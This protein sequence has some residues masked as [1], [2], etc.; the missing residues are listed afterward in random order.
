MEPSDDFRNK[1]HQLKSYIY[2]TIFLYVSN[3][4]KTFQFFQVFFDILKF[5]VADRDEKMIEM[6]ET[7]LKAT[8]Q[9]RNYSS[10]DNDPVFTQV[11]ELDLASV[12]SS[13]SGPKRPN[14][15][16]SVNAM[17]AD[18]AACLTN[19]VNN[20]IIHFTPKCLENT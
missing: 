10:T 9:F 15:R 8:K 11:V 7:Y 14:D 18:F 12:V 1:E 16:V 17:K 19:K 5:F 3:K 20:Q 2:K 4:S 13:V 6:I